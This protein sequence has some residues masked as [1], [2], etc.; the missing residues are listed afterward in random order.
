MRIHKGV[1]KLTLFEVNER[2]CRKTAGGRHSMKRRSPRDAEGF[3]Q[4]IS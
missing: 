3:L 4:N 2:R 1:V